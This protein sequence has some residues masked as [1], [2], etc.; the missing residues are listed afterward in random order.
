MAVNQ[1]IEEMKELIQQLIDLINGAPGPLPDPV[2]TASLDKADSAD[3]KAA[4][5]QTDSNVSSKTP[6]LLFTGWSTNAADCADEIMTYADAANA[7]MRNMPPDYQVVADNLH[8][9]RNGIPV[10]KSDIEGFG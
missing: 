6:V 7:E 3:D 4:D 10:V 5:A 1:D 9:V 8:T 2:K